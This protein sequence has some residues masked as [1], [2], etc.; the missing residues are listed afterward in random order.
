MRDIFILYFKTITTLFLVIDPV[1]LVPVYLAITRGMTVKARK[2]LLNKSII[3]AFILLG[4]FT[5]AGSGILWLFGID[6]HDFRIAGGLLFLLISIQIIF[7]DDEKQFKGSGGG[8]VPFATPIMVGPGVVTATIVLTGTV[9]VVTTLLSGIVAFI[10]TY[11]ILY[12]GREVLEVL[13]ENV[14]NVITKV[15]GL[16]L[17][18]ISIHYIREGVLG[19]VG[20]IRG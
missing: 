16:I 2:S 3:V 1:G 15:I 12:F 11:F 13:G 8:V 20:I 4:L 18:A 19:I 14:T 10:I 9:G 7:G 17:A 5:V 6:V